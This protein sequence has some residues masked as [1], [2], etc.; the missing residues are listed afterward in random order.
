MW[1]GDGTG[2]VVGN[3]N[4]VSCVT[5]S[6]TDSK[7]NALWKEGDDGGAIAGEHYWLVKVLRGDGVW[8]GLSSE[9]KFGPGYRCKGTM[10]GGPGNTSDG[11][12]LVTSQFGDAVKDGDEIGVLLN[13]DTTSGT[14]SV[15]FFH[16]H[17]PLGEAFRFQQTSPVPLF[18]VVGFSGKG[19]KAAI[20]KCEPPSERARATRAFEGYEG[21]FEL[22]RCS[23][24]GKEVEPQAS[25]EVVRAQGGYQLLMKA[26]NMMRGRVSRDESGDGWKGGP[27]MSTMMMVPETQEL[28][29][30]LSSIVEQLTDF[31]QTDVPGVAL[32]SG[33]GAAEF[34]RVEPPTPKCYTRNIFA[35]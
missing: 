31:K 20:T 17:R 4:E 30:A 14:T 7:F 21:H 33:D 1:T 5:E 16:N 11:G 13:I 25:M 34:V 19:E 32:V 2:A 35:E 18:P 27:V 26:G 3:G 22:R 8:V 23:L 15:S 9:T 24:G 12:A 10:Y 28:Q 29:A 6:T